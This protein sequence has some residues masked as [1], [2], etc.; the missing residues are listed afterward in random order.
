MIRIEDM[1]FNYE[2]GEKVL[3][4]INLTINR[5]EVICLT[6]A[7]GCGKTTVTRI[8]N[9]TVPH[10]YHGNIEGTVQVN[11]KD[12]RQQSIYEISKISGSVFQNP[13][14]QFFCLNTTSELAF[15]PE[16]YGVNPQRIVANINHSAEVLKMNHLLDRDIFNLSGGE[17]QLIACTAIQVSGHEIIILDEPSSN[18]DFTTITKL[19]QLLEQWKSEGKTIIIAEHRLHYLIDVVDRFVVMKYGEI[20]EIY[21]N[22]SFNALTHDN[23][24][25]LGLRSIHLD[26]MKPKDLNYNN[27]EE[28]L[29]LH[30]FIF[31][32]KAK[33]PYALNI[34]KVELPQ[35][36]VTAIIGSNGSGKSTF[37]RCLTGV[38]RKFKGHI[39]IN[40]KI[41]K[42]NQRL[43]HVY[44][45]F[46][47][48]N[49]QLF[50]ESVAEE[51]RLSNNKL[52]DASVQSRLQQYGISKHV[53]RH[54]LSL[55]G[56]EKQRL[57]IASAVETKR[58]V[59]IFDEP[60]SGLDGQRMREISGILNRLANQGHTVLVITHDYELLMACADEVL[61]LEKGCIKDQYQMDNEYLNKL[62]N[63]F[64]I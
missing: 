61:H 45:V 26:D 9:G 4:N 62:Q 64:E 39:D 59:L 41:L 31:N 44:M 32:Y 7:S 43:D 15:E 20:G 33:E 47:D 3:N 17:K 40:N 14:S 24:T 53:D 60:S 11:G 2:N 25:L 21:D 54:P 34:P 49:N 12:I 36:K 51:L 48:V 35:G 27:S 57:A 19:R 55:S 42:R 58:E 22:G 30:N 1:S 56:G 29:T 63:F 8:L 5:G 6:G 46:Q 10:L 37:A 38:E 23:L 18:L 13:R 52:N 28:K 50:A 16:N